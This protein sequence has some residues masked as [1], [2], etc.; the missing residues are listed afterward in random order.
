M[1]RAAC[2]RPGPAP[3]I[4]GRG[5]P[6]LATLGDDTQVSSRLPSPNGR[7]FHFRNLALAL[8]PKALAAETAGNAILVPVASRT[9]GAL[10]SEW[11]TDLV[12]S[13][14]SRRGT[15]V[16]FTITYVPNDGSPSTYATGE[17]AG[18]TSYTFPDIVNIGFGKATSAGLILVTSSSPDARLTAR[19]RIYNT[20]SGNGEFGQSV[21]GAR[22]SDLGREHHLAGLTGVDGNRTNVGISNPWSVASSF[23]ISVFDNEGEMKYSAG[24]FGVQ[25]R[26]VL[27]INDIF[28]WLGIAPIPNA[29]VE[30]TTERPAYVYASIVRADSGDP[31]FVQAV[32]PGDERRSRHP[33]RLRGAGASLSRDEPGRRVDRRPAERHG[34]RGRRVDPLTEVRLHDQEPFRGRVQGLHGGLA[35]AHLHCGPSVRAG[36]Q[37]HRTERAVPVAGALSRM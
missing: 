7:V 8:A 30:I 6:G 21:P 24:W 26:Q 27:Q 31:V 11:R 29:T 1:R 14:V 34:C 17:I 13:N 4:K 23:W 16:P 37:V 18:R 28:T 25:P 33:A 9:P 2:G 12:I 32:S 35:F 3:A 20:A 5:R 36:R 15:P 22:V 10:G 19:A